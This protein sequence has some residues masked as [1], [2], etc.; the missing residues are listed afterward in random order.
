ML[1]T[2]TGY[3][4]TGSS[5][6]YVLLKEY[7]GC[8]AGIFSEGNEEEHVLLY[9]PNGLFDLEDKLLMGNNLHRSDE[10]LRS[11]EQAMRRL[12]DNNFL[13][14]GNYKKLFGKDFWSEVENYISEL[15]DI[16]LCGDVFWYDNYLTTAFSWKHFLK[17]IW[18]L[19]RGR[20]IEGD[21]SKRIV[22]RE[23]E[24][25]RY[26]FVS[27]EQF[28][29]CSSKFI[30]AYS[31]LTNVNG[32]KNL[33]L[34]HFILPQNLYRLPN[35]FPDRDIRVIT[36][37]RDPRDV[38]VHL[39]QA[40]VNGEMG[41]GIPTQ[42]EDF[43][44][45]WKGSHSIIKDYSSEYVLDICFEDL[46]IKHDETVRKIESFCGLRTEQR[47]RK[48]KYLSV[49]KSLDNTQIFR[50]DTRW[51]K[52]VEYIEENLREYLYSF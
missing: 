4:D 49:E 30:Q 32:A 21:F 36:V 24:E 38:Y 43:V 13:W 7:E 31:R 5:A 50:R 11:F 18:N 6:V 17:N 27:P 39:M 46:L 2:T 22:F 34:D 41:K 12:Y 48:G 10:A 35:Y 51:Q 28:Y 37:E 15:T 42:V 1:I 29:R 19:L 23:V 44:K 3:F 9:M 14:F 33:I 26:S 52:E 16:K 8:D 47:I 40:A 25:I 45:F 20:K